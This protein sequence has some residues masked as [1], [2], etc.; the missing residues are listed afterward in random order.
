MFVVV[1]KPVTHELLIWSIGNVS[2]VVR[3]VRSAL[4]SINMKHIILILIY[5][6]TLSLLIFF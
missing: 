6:G 1:D 2:L 3:L 5:A 4:V